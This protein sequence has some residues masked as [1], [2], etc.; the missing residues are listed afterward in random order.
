M[1]DPWIWLPCATYPDNQ[2]TRYDAFSEDLEN[3]YTVAEFKRLYEFDKP[4]S[5]VKLR[6]SA[7][8][9]IQL[10][11]N[12]TLIATGPAVVGGDFLG[13]GKAREW[14]Y[15]TETEYVPNQSV[16]SFF[17][18]VKMCPVH[19][20]EYSKGQGGFMLCADVLFA[21]GSCEQIVTDESWSVRKNGAYVSSLVY[22]GTISP[23]PYINAE[24]I[25]DI[26]NVETAPIP[27]RTEEEIIAGELT[28]SPNEEITKELSL[29]M[30]YAGFLHVSAETEGVLFADFK[31]RELDEE[32]CSGESVKLIGNDEYRGFY[33]HSAGNII[34]NIKNNS[35]TPSKIKIGFITT[36]YPVSVDANTV[37]SDTELNNVLDVCKH[38]LKYC[39]QTH[40]LD[41]PRHCEP[42]ACTGD[43]YIESLMT[44]FSFGDMRL[45]EFDIIRTAELLR[46]ND[47]RMF[48]TTY[49]LIWVRMLYDTYM[50][51]GNADLLEK[52]RDALD[53]LLARFETYMGGNGI[54]ENPPDYMF[55][56]WIYI[57][58]I[59]MHHPPKCLGQ[60]VLNLFYYMA[61]NY[62]ERIYSTLKDHVSATQCREKSHA[63]KIAINA[64]LYDEEKGMY[65]E[66]LNTPGDEKQVA[67]WKWHPQ[68]VEKRYYLKQSNILAAYTCVCD[69][70]RAKMLIEK[71]MTDEIQ[72]G[73]QPYFTHYLLEAI[74][75]HG[76]REKYT[77]P[78][79]ERWKDSVKQCPKGLAEGFIA[80]EPTYRFD[81]SHAWGGTPLYSLPKA[82]LGLSIDEPA[83]K[84]ITLSPSLLGL[85]K[86]MVQLP[87]PYGM[88]ICEMEQGKEFKITAPDEIKIHLLT[89]TKKI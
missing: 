51:S 45:A 26:W 40:H 84:K 88:V 59:S 73:V 36:C 34:A 1:S 48:H 54:I 41:S 78:V 28:L 49:S 74:Y 63:L 50:I 62:A 44:A 7:D 56:D 69:S 64:L 23:D 58:D 61:L 67:E 25:D 14:Y 80:P 3:T 57:D 52:C 38:T 5:I 72:G 39:R 24:K 68:N 31:L 66:G 85:R 30:I 29:P 20:C 19:I 77:L 27:E 60:T 46:H 33:M 15:A 18:R 10:F 6:F 32:H 2:K 17:A 21:D 75:T 71:I 47:G 81:H 4:I 22:D 82:L 37:T 89:A 86:A 70:D 12:N 9:E 13:N 11:C 87:T 83:Y 8:T 76:L 16:L 43:Y 79:I 42:L 65:F 53:M 55:V 35:A